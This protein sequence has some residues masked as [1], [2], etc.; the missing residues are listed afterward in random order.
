MSIK[1]CAFV[2]WPGM[3]KEFEKVKMELNNGEIEK[4]VVR[5]SLNL[6]PAEFI[7]EAMTFVNSL[8]SNLISINE[9]T[10]PKSKWLGDDKVLCISIYYR[11]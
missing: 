7:N 10:Y 11:A 6:S 8:G 4:T 3:K 2:Y 9:Y 5:Y 1:R